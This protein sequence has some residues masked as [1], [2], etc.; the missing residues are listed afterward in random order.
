[1][2][3]METLDLIATTA[4][5]LEAVVKR[6]LQALGYEGKA[7]SPGWVEFRGDAAAICMATLVQND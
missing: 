6:E 5:G 4:F 7:I 2:A 3:T 1:M